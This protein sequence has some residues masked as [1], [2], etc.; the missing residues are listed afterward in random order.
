MTKMAENDLEQLFKDHADAVYRYCW[1][2]LGEFEADDATSEV[3][4]VAWKKAIKIPPEARKTWLLSVARRL[5]ANRLRARKN[6]QELTRRYGMGMVEHSPDPA[7]LVAGVD[8][9][10]RALMQLRSA[11]R[12]VLILSALDLSQADM[13]QALGCTSKAAG[14]R[15][16]RARARLTQALTSSHQKKPKRSRVPLRMEEIA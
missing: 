3:F 14:V 7:I 9:L 1:L 2:F 13:G 6:R 11:D 12:E 8:E 10:R 15:L 16:T 5:V 4:V